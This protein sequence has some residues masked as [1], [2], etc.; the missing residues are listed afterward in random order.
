[1][2]K[3]YSGSAEV[4][5]SKKGRR[6]GVQTYAVAIHQRRWQSTGEMI[7]TLQE[8]TD[9]PKFYDELARAALVALVDIHK[10]DPEVDTPLEVEGLEW[11]GKRLRIRREAI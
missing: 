7:V 4:S 5:I 8:A 10:Q 3:R 6:A 9:T 11:N 1:M 2:V